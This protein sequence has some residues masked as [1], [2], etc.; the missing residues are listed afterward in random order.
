MRDCREI[1]EILRH[2]SNTATALQNNRSP[3]C[4]HVPSTSQ[5]NPFSYTVSQHNI[6]FRCVIDTAFKGGL[7]R[8]Y[9]N[10][11]QVIYGVFRL[12]LKYKNMSIAKLNV[13]HP[14]KWH[15]CTLSNQM[16]SRTK[17]K[18]GLAYRQPQNQHTT[19]ICDSYM[20]VRLLRVLRVER[21]HVRGLSHEERG[22]LH[23]ASERW[24][25][26]TKTTEKTV[27]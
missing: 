7:H 9:T 26:H 25:E 14:I 12:A 22:D 20:C 8:H 16:F 5:P 24:T 6:S 15:K 17:T 23:P 11:T 3:S 13:K 1:E 10:I 27:S 21:A 4:P 2:C 19:T 18:C